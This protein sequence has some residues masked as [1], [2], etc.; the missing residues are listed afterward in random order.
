MEKFA[1]FPDEGERNKEDLI[2]LLYA[3]AAELMLLGSF[4]DFHFDTWSD[5]A[6]SGKISWYIGTAHNPDYGDC[7]NSLYLE[8]GWPFDEEKCCEWIDALHGFIYRH[9]KGLDVHGNLVTKPC[10]NCEGT[11]I[12]FDDDCAKP[13][14]LDCDDWAHLGSAS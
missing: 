7:A 12:T 4:A 3:K 6:G 14:C 10:S 8:G 11:R 1:N 9:Y 5:C 2:R 13:W